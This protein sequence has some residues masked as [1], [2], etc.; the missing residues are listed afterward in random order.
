MDVGGL[1]DKAKGKGKDK[2]KTKG[3]DKRKCLNWGKVGHWARGCWTAGGGLSA[4]KGGR[5]KGKPKDGKFTKITCV[6]SGR[7]ATWER[8]AV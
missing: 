7:D 4:G 1:Y 6:M 8:I 3:G 5:G 2:S